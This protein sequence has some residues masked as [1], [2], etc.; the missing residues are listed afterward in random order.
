ML[1][2]ELT[3]CHGRPAT[4]KVCLLNGANRKLI[5]NH[6]F[7]HGAK[8]A[9]DENFHRRSATMARVALLMNK[10]TM[11]LTR[12]PTTLEQYVKDLK[13]QIK[14]LPFLHGAA[15]TPGGKPIGG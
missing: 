5:G 10:G 6:W 13:G 14:E 8:T 2:H 7:S 9:I 1:A 11:P 4:M 15:Q 3:V 12:E